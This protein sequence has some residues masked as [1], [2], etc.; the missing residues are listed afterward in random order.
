MTDMLKNVKSCQKKVM[1]VMTDRK[2]HRIYYRA[3]SACR[4]AQSYVF[5]KNKSLYFAVHWGH[6]ATTKLNKIFA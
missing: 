6:P 3:N 5:F 4:I 2:R 1:L